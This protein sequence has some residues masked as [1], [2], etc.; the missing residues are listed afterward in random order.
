MVENIKEQILSNK[1]KCIGQI[2]R[3]ILMSIGA[4][5]FIQ[6]EWDNL[7]KKFV[8]RGSIT[9]EKT[10]NKFK[11]ILDQNQKKVKDITKV[12]QDNL[13]SFE[14]ILHK[15]NI[16]TKNDIESLYERI[17]KLDNR[18]SKFSNDKTE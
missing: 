12:F 2:R 10:I 17:E 7:V 13:G 5:T 9:E 6:D 1:N 4:V 8:K 15:L 16:P 3:S 14:K 11:E 18:I